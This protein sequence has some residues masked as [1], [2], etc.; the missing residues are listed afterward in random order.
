MCGRFEIHS[1][2]KIIAEL[3]GIDDRFFDF[4]P[5]YN[6]A[7]SQDVLTVFREGDRNVPGLCRWGFLPPWA[8]TPSEGFK[9]INARAETLA[10]KPSF[11][12]AF[13]YRRC[14]VIADG[15]FEWKRE[16]TAREPYYL[17]LASRQPFGFAGLYSD[18]TSLEGES[19]RTATIITTEANALVRP[20]HDRMPAI[21][22]ADKQERWLDPGIHS[23]VQLMPILA[24]YPA[25]QMECYGVSRQVNSVKVNSPENIFPAV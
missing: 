25:D 14:L 12:E 5:N 22:P 21:V 6:V 13:R 11:R 16:G 24:P 20:L 9:M 2:F 8:K 23:P 18:W 15:F 10:E 17:R 1:A 3:F 7:P 4:Q 19:L